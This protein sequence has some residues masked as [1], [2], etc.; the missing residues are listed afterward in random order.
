MLVNLRDTAAVKAKMLNPF[1]PGDGGIWPQTPSGSLPISSSPIA[2]PGPFN[3]GL[4][5]PTYS[6]MGQFT[7][8]H[9]SNP[10]YNSKR[11]ALLVNSSDVE[12]RARL[13]INQL[14]FV[15]GSEIRAKHFNVF[16][17]SGFAQQH[18]LMSNDRNLAGLEVLPGV[19]TLEPSDILTFPMLNYKMRTEAARKIYGSR[20]DAQMLV[21]DYAFLGVQIHDRSDNNNG[22]TVA[23][24]GDYTTG[25][26]V[27]ITQAGKAA[28]Y[29][30]WSFGISEPVDEGAHLYLLWRKQPYTSVLN[31]LGL[32][33]NS[34]LE[35]RIEQTKRQKTMSSA[36]RDLDAFASDSAYN[37]RNYTSNSDA[38]FW[39]LEPWFSNSREPPHPSL[40]RG[41]DSRGVRWNG[42][43]FYIGHA[44]HMYGS[45]DP[46]RRRRDIAA[47]TDHMYPKMGDNTYKQPLN[48]HRIPLMDIMVG[49]K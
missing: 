28:V 16:S 1:A 18:A 30:I 11:H 42:A 10:S 12:A 3:L 44:K 5:V 46:E 41:F 2:A 4:S 39:R 47:Y 21:R 37:E 29:N 34:R 38:D 8:G 19:G 27:T 22:P 48:D 40:L 17:N 15:R 31:A 25:I 26:K 35:N 20:P 32:F 45:A 7:A 14:L 6:D 43:A 9:P 24:L 13:G 33:E 49:I 23:A 36:Y